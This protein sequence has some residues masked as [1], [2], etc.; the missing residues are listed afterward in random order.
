MTSPPPS[1][2]IYH[3]THVSNL[4]AIVASGGLLSDRAMRSRGGPTA[5]I[6]MDTIKLRRMR[7][8]VT[9]HPGDQVG[10]YVPFYFCPRSIMLY[11]IYCKNHPSLTYRGGQ[12][13]IVHLE[14]Q[15]RWT[16]PSKHAR[17]SPQP[18]TNRPSWCARSGTTS[19][20]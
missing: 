5:D 18:R 20:R 4:P 12:E 6:G 3:I 17:R 11:V 7:L 8:P 13:P 19:S 10:D 16:S 1:P 14:A 2:C 15:R 9:C